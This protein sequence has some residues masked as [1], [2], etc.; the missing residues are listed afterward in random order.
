MA[1]MRKLPSS[2]TSMCIRF[3]DVVTLDGVAAAG[4]S[5]LRELELT[6]CGSVILLENLSGAKLAALTH[7]NLSCCASLLN[8][9]G[10]SSVARAS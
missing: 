3:C 7:L 4:L 6:R 10:L 8:L 9:R 2:L 5:Q 1:S